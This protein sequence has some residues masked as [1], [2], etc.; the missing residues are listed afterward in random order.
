MPKKSIGQ[1]FLDNTKPDTMPRPPQKEGAPQPHLELPYDESDG[2][3]IPLKAERKINLDAK[4]L[5]EA[6]IGRK[7]HR[8]Y[9]HKPITLDELTYALYMTQGVKKVVKDKVTFRTVPSA[10]ARHAFETILLVNNVDGLERG[11]YRYLALEH[12]LQRL[13]ASL[14]ITQKVR[15]ACLKQPQI[16]EAGVVFLWIADT[17]RMTY[18]YGERG[19]RYIFLDA[20]HV[21][22]NLYLV[23]EQIGC[24]V[25]AIAAY[26]DDRLNTLLGLDGEAQFTAYVASLGKL[27]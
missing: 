13:E 6:L 2:E 16:E 14:D 10:G 22:E 11:L 20:G 5:R 7:T 17:Y 4:D 1:S 23:A 26:D 3:I 21:A 25:C 24:G 15:R 8:T 9:A 27:E 12:K 18:R 19:Y